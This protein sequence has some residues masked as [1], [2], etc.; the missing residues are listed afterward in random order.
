MESPIK[1]LWKL[2]YCGKKQTF[3]GLSIIPNIIIEKRGFYLNSTSTL[4]YFY[5]GEIRIESGLKLDKVAFFLN[6]LKN[7]SNF[8]QVSAKGFV[9]IL[10]EN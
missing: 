7:N 9:Q 1:N 8:Y 5:P 4:F 2:F 10:I 3:F 6:L